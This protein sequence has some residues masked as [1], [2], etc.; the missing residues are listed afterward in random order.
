MNRSL[1]LAVAFVA[2]LAPLLAM[3]VSGTPHDFS[4]W[5]STHRLAIADE[6]TRDRSWRGTLEAFAIYDRHIDGGAIR[7]LADRVFPADEGFELGQ[8]PFEPVAYWKNLNPGKPTGFLELSLDT[9]TRVYE[10]LERSGK[11]SLLAWL[12]VNDL[13]QIEAERIVTL[14]RDQYNRNFTLGQEGGV[15]EFR[16]RTPATGSNGYE[17]HARTAEILEPGRSYFVAATY[18]GFVSRIFVDGE[19]LGRKSLAGSAARVPWLHDL[20]LPLVLALCGGCFAGVLVVLSR[21]TRSSV[22]FL[23]GCAG[24][25]LVVA[26]VWMLG[27]EVPVWPVRPVTPLWRIVPPLVGGLVVALSLTIRPPG[28]DTNVPRSQPR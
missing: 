5:D 17:P 1:F 27:E 11:M 4:N 21:R 14:S 24:G 7:E 10:S 12:R 3:A 23:L 16:L 2:G 18:D 19:L 13:E 20:N 26:V 15:L 8:L 25:L 6:F 28:A 9:S 22:R